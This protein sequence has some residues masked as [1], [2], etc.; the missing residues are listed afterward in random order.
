MTQN[1]QDYLRYT[2][3]LIESIDCMLEFKD[4]CQELTD[5][6]SNNF[7]QNA[8]NLHILKARASEELQYYFIGKHSA[9][10]V[11]N[12]IMEDIRFLSTAITHMEKICNR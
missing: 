10:T 3:Y 5:Q 1:Q 11:R 2:Q 9:L 7:V 8:S 12:S 4:L 6:K